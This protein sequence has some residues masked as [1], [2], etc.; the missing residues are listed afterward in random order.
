MPF[1]VLTLKQSNVNR[2]QWR[3][4]VLFLLIGWM[5]L[6]IARTRE[7]DLQA[8]GID[9]VLSR[10][11]PKNRAL[12][13]IFDSTPETNIAP[14]FLHFPS[15]YSAKKQGVVD[16]SFALFHP[17]LV[18][19]KESAIPSVGIGYEW[20]PQTFNWRGWGADKYRYFVVHA[21][22]DFGASLAYG[23]PCQIYFV[24]RSENWWL[25]E[26]DSKCNPTLRLPD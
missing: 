13:L 2:P 21:P 12:S 9:E 10:M 16:V 22:F 4:I 1:F 15:W 3:A 26:R 17:E 24:T 18:A 14:V 20:D 25:Y 8:K 23:S 11:E 19:Y 5:I 7:Y 6:M